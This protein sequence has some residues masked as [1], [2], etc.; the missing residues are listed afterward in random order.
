M[1]FME[2]AKYSYLASPVFFKITKEI[3]ETELE[4]EANGG[5]LLTDALY[6]TR[7]FEYPWVFSQISPDN[8]VVLDAGGGPASFQ[9]Y[10]A[11]KFHYVHNIDLLDAWVDKVNDTKW[12]TGL[13]SNLTIRKGDLSDLSHIPDGLF[14]V[15]VCISVVEHNGSKALRMVDEL[16]RVTSGDVFVTV[17]VGEDDEELLPME[18][19]Y[20]MEERYGFMIPNVP[21]D[22]IRN[23]TVRG[24]DFKVACMRLERQ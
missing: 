15:A 19:L 23:K 8:K 24:N 1:S 13:F 21:P 4:I 20:E 17:D 10:L 18:T 5:Q 3:Y 6:L 22:V 9:Y 2:W 16:L 14:D 12:V 11:K 7:R